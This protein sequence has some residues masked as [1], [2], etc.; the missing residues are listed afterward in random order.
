MKLVLNLFL[1]SFLFFSLS[2]KLSATDGTQVAPP[3]TN[4]LLEELKVFELKIMESK[5]PI[6][7]KVSCCG[8]RGKGFIAGT[9]SL[10]VGSA[11]GTLSSIYGI[12]PDVYDPSLAH[13]FYSIPPGNERLPRLLGISLGPSLA[14]AGFGGGVAMAVLT[15][16]RKRAIHKMN[17]YCKK[18]RL[19]RV[20]ADALALCEQS[21]QGAVS[22]EEGFERI[23]ELLTVYNSKRGASIDLGAFA[24]KIKT[25]FESQHFQPQTGQYWMAPEENYLHKIVEKIVKKEKEL[26]ELRQVVAES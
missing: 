25:L 11:L 19:H 20:I 2:F 16:L 8:C 5:D 4:T 24:H 9:I 21:E 6:F 22:N 12:A 1:S 17:A 26:Q 3:I 7:A 13:Y 23:N 15:C 18:F 10:F 14:I